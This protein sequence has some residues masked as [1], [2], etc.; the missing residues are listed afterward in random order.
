[1]SVRIDIDREE[2][3]APFVDRSGVGNYADDGSVY[4]GFIIRIGDTEL[5]FE[6]EQ[7]AVALAQRILIRMGELNQAM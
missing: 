5:R 6:H 1:M 7:D 3:A 2:G 4:E